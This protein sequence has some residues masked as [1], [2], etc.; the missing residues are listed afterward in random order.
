M[1]SSAYALSA[2][3][4]H[5]SPHIRLFNSRESWTL[6]GVNKSL[7]DKLLEAFYYTYTSNYNNN[8]LT[9]IRSGRENVEGR[10]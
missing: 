4:D 1:L 2:N 7:F 10:K 9:N 3:T 5:S 8:Q 6:A